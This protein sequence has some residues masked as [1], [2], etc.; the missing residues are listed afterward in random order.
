VRT[1]LAIDDDVLC[2]AKET[3]RAE[4]RSTGE[5]ISAMARLG[6]AKASS[7]PGAARTEDALGALGITTLPRRGGI[8]T[9]E[10]VNEIRDELG[11]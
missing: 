10:L 6:F 7:A 11:V 4:G 8:V 9:Q 2:A 5:V 3:A 1:T